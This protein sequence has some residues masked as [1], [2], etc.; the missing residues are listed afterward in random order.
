MSDNMGL[1]TFEMSKNCSIFHRYLPNVTFI[2]LPRLGFHADL[3][4]ADIYICNIRKQTHMLPQAFWERD[5]CL[6]LL[7]KPSVLATAAWLAS[8]LS[9]VAR[10]VERHRALDPALWKG[11]QMP[12]RPPELP[13]TTPV[14]LF[15]L[16]YAASRLLCST[17]KCSV[18]TFCRT[19]LCLCLRS[20]LPVPSPVPLSF[21][22]KFAHS[23][24]NTFPGEPI[25]QEFSPVQNPRA[26]NS[27]N[28]SFSTFNIVQH[29]VLLF[30][31]PPVCSSS[32]EP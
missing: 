19:G 17:N 15:R 16:T 6:Y 18:Q 30:L 3:G 1:G 11:R 27:P 25:L 2:K 31:F 4:A 12:V 5:L 13:P 24:N 9:G 10:L 22:P 14:L 7:L 21:Y 23:L 8:S 26:L 32:P 28:Y 20:K 29:N